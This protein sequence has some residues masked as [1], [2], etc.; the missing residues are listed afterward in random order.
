M[1]VTWVFFLSNDAAKI[2]TTSVPRKSE[3]PPYE[4]CALGQP[5]PAPSFAPIKNACSDEAGVAATPSELLEHMQTGLQ[6]N[7]K[8]LNQYG[9]LK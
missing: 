1:E 5:A 6:T 7:I 9:G 8:R 3:S 4:R 2:C